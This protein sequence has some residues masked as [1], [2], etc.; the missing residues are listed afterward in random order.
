MGEID[1]V[2]GLL[3][4]RLSNV[5]PVVT[6]AG[7]LGAGAAVR[8]YREGYTSDAELLGELQQLGYPPS[9]S[10]RYQR[11]AHLDYET[12]LLADLI[13]AHRTAF[14]KGLIT[15]EQL[16]SALDELGLRSER[17]EAILD[18]EDAKAATKITTKPAKK[19]YETAAG[20]ARIAAAKAEYQSGSI[21]QGELE[22]ALGAEEMPAELVDATVQLEWAKFAAR[23][24]AAPARSAP[25]YESDASKRKITA[26]VTLYV[27]GKA[28]EAQLR[29]KL[30][31]LGLPS[32]LIDAEIALATARK[33]VKPVPAPK[34][35]PRELAAYETPAGRTRVATLRAMYQEELIGDDDLLADLRQLEVPEDLA[36]AILQQEQVQL[37][38]AG[39]SG[40][41]GSLPAY[42]TP[43]G[44]IRVDTARLRFRRGLSDLA[45][46]H[47]ALLQA[48]MPEELAV[49]IEDYE[50]TRI[51]QAGASS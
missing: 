25:E 1:A 9:R 34:K 8:R 47:A 50:A 40:P 18:I 16:G 27:G 7:G 3:Q 30:T 46:L 42:K 15:R 32:Y 37:A 13:T 38:A 41:V 29:A 48:G 26:A 39:V 22:D 12:D 36:T 43:A 5:K 21:S 24:A 17:I 49:A 19:R 10:E 35:P 44:K 51:A 2:L 23:R 45:E 4:Q 11:Q 33:E 14:G 20:K 28:D 31:E 6:E